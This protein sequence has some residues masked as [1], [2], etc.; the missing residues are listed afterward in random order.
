MALGSAIGGVARYL[1]FMFSPLLPIWSLLVIN[2]LGSFLFGL[3]VQNISNEELRL[4]V[5]VGLMG[6]FTTFS[7]FSYEVVSLFQRGDYL[8]G[9]VYVGLSLV[10]T[11]GC[12]ALGL[13]LH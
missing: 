6:S 5:L 7:T 2:A 13:K 3:F 12:M 8:W 4:L 10:I 9:F 11:L 1:L